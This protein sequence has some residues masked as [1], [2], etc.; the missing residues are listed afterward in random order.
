MDEAKFGRILE[1]G[2]GAILSLVLTLVMM[3]LVGAPI[4]LHS[5]LFGWAGSF[6][7]AVAINYFFPVMIWCSML[8]KNIRNK[9]AEYIVRVILFSFIEIL[10]NSVWC[11]INANL[12]GFWPSKFPILLVVGTPVIFIFLPIM[13]RVA[14]A[15]SK[16]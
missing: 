10:F 1:T 13:T 8:T 5:V 3:L 7:I 12:I 16:K 6:A 14:A 15:L 4:T 11:M 2:M 9:A